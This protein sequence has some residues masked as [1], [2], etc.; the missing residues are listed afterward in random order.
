MGQ[1]VQ[2]ILSAT[3]GQSVNIYY[4]KKLQVDPKRPKTQPLPARFT[5]PGVMQT[6]RKRQCDNTGAVLK[7]HVSN[8]THIYHHAHND[9]DLMCDAL[10]WVFVGP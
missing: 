6:V 10:P 8:S 5:L 7:K 3:Y 1:W 2:S 4:V 9:G